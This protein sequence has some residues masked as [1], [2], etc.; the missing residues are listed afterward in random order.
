[1]AVIPAFGSRA[2]PW[3]TEKP[4]RSQKQNNSNQ[5]KTVICV[6]G[7]TCAWQ[8]HRKTSGISK[9]IAQQPISR[10]LE[11]TS[12]TRKKNSQVEQRS[13][14]PVLNPTQIINSPSWFWSIH[15]D[16]CSHRWHWVATKETLSFISNSD[17]Q[18][19]RD[20]NNNVLVGGEGSAVKG[21]AALA[22]DPF[23]FQQPCQ[24]ATT[25]CYQLILKLTRANSWCSHQE[26]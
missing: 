8:W 18:R 20:Q 7:K 1:M 13:F 14:F 24:E 23:S 10:T 6:M 16:F 11:L 4:Y 12:K 15:F 5:N 22:E 3:V 25:T 26:H 19:K 21:C 9:K 2:Q 17:L